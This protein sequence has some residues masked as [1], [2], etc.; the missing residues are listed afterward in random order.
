MTKIANSEEKSTNR[1]ARV[2]KFTKSRGDTDARERQDPLTYRVSSGTFFSRSSGSN[3][4]VVHVARFHEVEF[5]HMLSPKSTWEL[6][7]DGDV[8]KT[9]IVVFSLKGD[10]AVVSE[11]GVC[12]E[13]PGWP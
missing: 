7:R 9:M 5:T 11:D 12:T 10:F 13:P 8:L 3:Q 6:S 2:S 1:V 4:P